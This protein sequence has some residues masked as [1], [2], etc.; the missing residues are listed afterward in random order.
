MKKLR[1]FI[2]DDH[3]IFRKGLIQLINEEADMEVCGEAE[4]VFSATHKVR[5]LKPD[6]VIVDITLKDTSGLE[7]IKFIQDNNINIPSLVLSM[8]DEKVYAE[9]ALVSGARGYIMKQE[10][11]GQ[12]TSAI[13]QIL[14]GKI[15]ISESMNERLLNNFLA[16]GGESGKDIHDNDPSSILTGRELEI[17]RLIGKGYTRKDISEFL[18]LNVN[19]IGTYRERIKEKMNISSSNELL[20][21]A[22]KWVQKTE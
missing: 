6:L 3:P 1:I 10:M 4:D 13:R 12:V 11:S 18:N 9:R 17:F 20:S 7:L 19:T 8:H 2:V 14:A 21:Y 22:I 16:K 15:Y 5:Q